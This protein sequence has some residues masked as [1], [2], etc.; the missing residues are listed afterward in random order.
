MLFKLPLFLVPLNGLLMFSLPGVWL[1]FKRAARLRLGGAVDRDGAAADQVLGLA[2]G[3]G[4]AGRLEGLGQRD[5]LA[6][7]LKGRHG[8]RVVGCL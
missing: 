6:A 1:Y 2:A 5:V 4:Q 3:V 8:R 7:E